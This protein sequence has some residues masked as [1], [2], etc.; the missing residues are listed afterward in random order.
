[1]T[2]ESG[3][4]LLMLDSYG[5][6]TLGLG[7]TFA[8]IADDINAISVNPAGLSSL[9][10]FEAT[11]MYMRYSFDM[12]FGY[13][14]A[15]GP[16]ADGLGSIGGS[17]ALF[18]SGDFDSYDSEGNKESSPLSAS[19]FGITVGYANNPLK[20]LNVDQNLNLGLNIKFVQSK[21]ADDSK[22]AVVFDMSA[23]Y[24]MS[25]FSFG[26]GLL[27]ENLGIGISFQ[28]LGP[29]VKYKAEETLLPRNFRIG[30][31]YQG[32]HDD[33]HGI[34]LG[35]DINFPNDSKEIIG[36]GLEYSFIEMIFIRIG[37]KFSGTEMD[38]FSAGIGGKYRLL[39]KLFSLDYALIPLTDFDTMH[40]ISL[41]VKF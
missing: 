15:G 25:V 2:G 29:S 30:A 1:G 39:E 20:L 14:A 26:S 32:Y 24:R 37:Y 9:T 34:L 33:K 3:I 31:G 27:K 7:D 23:L 11:T 4:P 16:L 40:V 17:L 5:E 28:N 18:R 36:M 6:R 19:D 35:F 13:L 12:M 22:T 41:G 21:L 8:G 10:S 38:G